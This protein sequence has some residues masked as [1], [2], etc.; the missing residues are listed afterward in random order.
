[1]DYD[2]TKRKGWSG[3][4][5][6][7]ISLDR[8]KLTERVVIGGTREARGRLERGTG[9]VYYDRTRPL[10]Q[11][12][13]D[14]EAD[15]DRLWTANAIR[16]K[17]SYG[18]TFPF[19]R[20]RWKF[21]E[22]SAAFLRDQYISGKPAAMFAAIRTW[23]EYL[24]LY[25]QDHGADLFAKHMALLYRPFF[26]YG[27]YRPWQTEVASLSVQTL[28]G[29]ESQVE[30]WYPAAKWPFECVVAFSSFQPVVFY[31]LN[32][33]EEW[34]FVFQKCKVCGRYFM[35]RSRHYELCSDPC[36]KVQAVEAKRQFDERAKGSRPEQLYRSAYYY[37]YNRLRNLKRTNDIAKLATA[38]ESFHA[39]RVE[40]QK[41]K[42]EVR[43]GQLE[44]SDFSQWLVGQQ[45][46][47]D[48]LVG[49]E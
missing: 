3:R 39:F 13:I 37:W 47:I 20:E 2:F 12:L 8:K 49:H 23:E 16:L 14:F 21:A 24:N 36:R 10:G 15:P 33:I 7:V 44:L 45:D 38:E 42:S 5:V 29:S 35:A 1:M 27:E 22:Q 30:L 4:T 17:E 9:N 34:G 48:A 40:A 28:H 11:W 46:I 43:C 32:K 26:L 25:Y 41:Q 6:F 19:E 31:C 18:K